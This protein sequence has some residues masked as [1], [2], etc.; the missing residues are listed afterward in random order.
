[1]MK[2]VAKDLKLN[3]F[4]DLTFVEAYHAINQKEDFKKQ[5]FSNIGYVLALAE[6]RMNLS[7]RLKMVNYLKAYPDVEKIPVRAPVF[8]FG[9]GR[10]GTTFTH[11]LLSLDPKV[12]SPRLWEL[13]NPVPDISLN[14]LSPRELFEKD[15]EKRKEFIRQR[16]AERHVL[17]DDGLEKYHEVGHDL[18]EECLF[19]MCDE[20]PTIF[21]YMFYTIYNWK[22]LNRV[23]SPD[24]FVRAYTWYKKIL[25]VLSLQQ[26][27]L[28]NDKRWVLKSP[29]HVFMIPY[30]VKAFPDA[31]AH[32]H[33]VPT[34]SSICSLLTSMRNIYFQPE[35][36]DHREVGQTFYN[37]CADIVTETPKAIEK[38][39]VPCS[40][41]LFENLVADPIE[42]VKGIYKDLDL[43]FTPEYEDILKKYLEENRKQR[44][45]TKKKLA[46]LS[47]SK[48]KAAL[49]EHR[50]EDF[51]LTSESLVQGRYADY[52]KK[53]K[54]TSAK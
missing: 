39:G 25:Q 27:D 54:I 24:D 30:L 9:L 29:I 41:V 45:E 18:P 35:D 2:I 3:D 36:V 14:A 47:G 17:G 34:V 5:K 7:R 37:L 48:H 11:R 26:G 4:G 50:P 6:F 32:R 12:R 38:S 52:I 15:C 31:K 22:E 23:L 40:H 21:H 19:A 51:F 20:I 46:K 49:H 43:E 33:P 1:M 42:T 44:E 13:V 28:Q 53:F 16:I 10:S 8:V